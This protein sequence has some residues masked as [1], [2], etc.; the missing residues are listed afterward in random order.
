[1]KPQS[2]GETALGGVTWNATAV[3]GSVLLHL[4]VLAVLARLLDPYDF[5]VVGAALIV[6]GFSEMFSK[7]GIGPAI[8]QVPTLTRTFQRT[9]FGLALLMGAGTGLAVFLA[10]PLIAAFFRMEELTAVIRVLSIGF[11]ITALGIVPEAL[12]LRELAFRAKALITLLS[13]GIGYGALGIGLGLAGAGIWALV[14]AHLGKSAVTVILSWYVKKPG[15]GLGGA[16]SDLRK[17]FRFG[18][19]MSLADIG[20]YSAGK[21]DEVVVGRWLGAEALGYYGRAYE[22]MVAPV[23]L[24][25]QATE[26][27]MFPILASIQDS[28]ERMR[29]VF[30]RCI[31]VIAI[32]TLPVSALIVVLA[33]EIVRV[34][35]G[36]GWGETVL[37]L[38]ILSVAILF[39]TS[40]KVSNSLAR[41]KA[42]VYRSAWRQWI[43]AGAV[44][45][46]AAC[47]QRWG[48]AGV[49]AG[50]GLAVTLHF[51]SMLTLSRDLIDGTWAELAR[52][53]RPGLWL[54]ICV[55]PMGWSTAWAT[56]VLDAPDTAVVFSVLLAGIVGVVLG[57]RTLSFEGF[58]NVAWVLRNGCTKLGLSHKTSQAGIR[59]LRGKARITW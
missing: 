33:P 50:V 44:F 47:G 11:P 25:G 37:P 31:S 49:A 20:N 3:A 36:P 21:G 57:C 10:A 23:K 54:A 43:Y 46:G 1:M 5:G 48:I 26:T 29:Q 56:R 9:A 13:V 38:Q 27:V 30:Y 14:S 39:R 24:V 22:F 34:L 6:V 16:I 59:L 45:L 40:Y 12:L 42:A 17:I 15:V 32:V 4:A 19:G 2:L 41:A 28:P 35:L 18:S 7:L 55:V 52:E 8:V 53:H 51:G 58:K